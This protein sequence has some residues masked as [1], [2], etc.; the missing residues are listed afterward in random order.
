MWSSRCIERTGPDFCRLQERVLWRYVSVNQP[1]S[2]FP[3][4]AKRA[5][6][7]P[8]DGATSARHS[9]SLCQQKWRSCPGGRLVGTNTRVR[10]G[11]KKKTLVFVLNR[12]NWFK[13]VGWKTL[14]VVTQI[15]PAIRQHARLLRDI[16][17]MYTTNN[18]QPKSEADCNQ[19]QFL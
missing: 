18:V 4:Q 3:A 1:R 6:S 8:Q 5:V 14:V 11:K 9:Q 7:G 17:A 19:S 2:R 13:Q 10:A 16:V 15:G 12:A